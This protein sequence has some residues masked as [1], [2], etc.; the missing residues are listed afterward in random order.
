MRNTDL[1]LKIT[2]LST[3]PYP[4]IIRTMAMERAAEKHQVISE[5][6]LLLV[7]VVTPASLMQKTWG[8]SL[9]IIPRAKYLERL[10]T[11]CIMSL[12][13]KR[14]SVW[15]NQHFYPLI[16]DINFHRE[17]V[18]YVS[19]TYSHLVIIQIIQQQGENIMFEKIF[20]FIHTYFFT[21][22]A[23]TT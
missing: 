15:C 11:F 21:T 17:H 6:V 13:N 23:D 9:I 12:K 20:L 5:L 4:S 8:F 3:L 18:N 19:Y 16:A 14:I 22:T 10:T 2:I 7:M 1:L